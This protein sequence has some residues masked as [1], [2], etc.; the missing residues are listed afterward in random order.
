MANISDSQK[1]L[2]TRGQHPPHMPTNLIQLPPPLALGGSPHCLRFHAACP[3]TQA[4]GPLLIWPSAQA[5]PISPGGYKREFT[6]LPQVPLMLKTPRAPSKSLRQGSAA[7]LPRPRVQR[8]PHLNVSKCGH[9]M[10]A[11]LGDLEPRAQTHLGS[12][13]APPFSIYGNSGP[14][15][16][17]SLCFPIC[18]MD[19]LS[20]PPVA[21]SLSFSGLCSNVTF[22]GKP[23]FCF[24]CFYCTFSF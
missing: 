5:T 12:N 22:T 20:H 9:T 8:D 19:P 3:C 1:A 21:H 16:Y 14:F 13:R 24:S 15:T 2:A 10:I 6:I 18:R 7:E 17:L 23:S 11:T 4:S